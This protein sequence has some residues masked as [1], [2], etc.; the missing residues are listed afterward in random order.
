MK[1]GT[2]LHRKK[3]K[4]ISKFNEARE[5]KKKGLLSKDGRRKK[6]LK[7]DRWGSFM[8]MKGKGRKL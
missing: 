2:S 5:K 1:V 6:F 8:G 4:N 3:K 7:L